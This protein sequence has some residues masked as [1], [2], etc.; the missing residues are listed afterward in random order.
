ME[1]KSSVTSLKG[2]G[3]KNA[4]LLE[5]LQI[6]TIDDLIHHL[7]KDYEVFEDAVKADALVENQRNAFIGKILTSPKLLRV[8]HLTILNFMAGEEAHQVKITIF[9]MPY[10]AKTM[11]PGSTYVF[12]GN[13]Y[14]KGNSICMDQPG[15][16]KPEV[17]AGKLNVLQPSYVKTKGLSNEAMTKYIQTSLKEVTDIPET[18]PE[19]AIKNLGFCSHLEALKII[20][21]PQDKKQLLLAKKR[22][23]YEEFFYFLLSMHYLKETISENGAEAKTML[24]TADTKR[25]IEKLPYRLTQSQKEVF[26]ELSKQMC[27]QGVTVN[28]LIQGDVGSG[29]TIIAILCLLLCVS[30]GYQGVMMAPT[31]VLAMQHFEDIVEMTKKYS[32]PFKPVLLTGSLTAKQKRE[33]K[34]GLEEGLYNLV[35]GT[36]ALLEDNVVFKNLALVITDEQHRFGVAQRDKL[37]GKGNSVHTIVMSATPIPRSLAIVLYGNLDVS[38]IK[39]LPSNRLPIKNCVVGPNYRETAHK[40]ILDEVKKGRQAYVICPMVESGVMEELENVKDYQKLLKDKYGDAV[41]VSYLHGK[42]RPKEKNEIM[43]EFALGNIDVLVST[44]VIEVGIN[45]PNATVM[46]IENADRF[47]LATLHQ[48][49]GRVGRGEHQSYCIFVDTKGSKT[50]KERLEILNHSNDG[51]HIANEDLKLRGPGD[52]LGVMQSGD[53]AFR[54]AD[55]YDDSAMLM[56]ASNDVKSLL[57][58]D[59]LLQSTEHQVIKEQLL[60]QAD[61]DYRGVL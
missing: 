55:I 14:R 18:L 33:A 59:P 26:T 2:I 47:G 32:L 48:I 21:M 19:K 24:E 28:R 17:Y 20:H 29:K 51:F 9:N 12:V 27:T 6:R 23:A 30:N 22:L 1:L 13:V 25:L 61:K 3:E 60:K 36:H 11:K 44:T 8:K 58:D 52:M 4:L 50:S 5:K 15:I 31:E 35:I 39:E 7:P 43:E 54:F 16:Y 46:M 42:M 41:R 37:A 10:L 56:Q 57:A 38:T 45:V 53:F 49:R 34:E 40:F